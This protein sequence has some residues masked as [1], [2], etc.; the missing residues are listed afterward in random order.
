MVQVFEDCKA[1]L[2]RA[3]LLA[4]PDP[5]APLALFTDASDTAIGAALQQ[6]VCDAWQPLAFYSHNLSPAQQKYSPYNQELLAV[7]EAIK[8][9]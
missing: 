8:Y 2:S 1:S 7:Y 4:P 6:R 9:F 5:S 3:T